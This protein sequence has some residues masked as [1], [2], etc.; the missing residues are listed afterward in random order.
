MMYILDTNVIAD[1][2]HL[3][4]QVRANLA[5]ARQANAD[6]MMTR[7]VYY[8][9]VRGLV[10]Q[11]ATR[12]LRIFRQDL[13]PLMKQ[14]PL[15]DEDWEQAAHFWAAAVSKGRQLSD[16][17]LLLAAMAHRRGATLIS[18][19]TDFDTLPIQRQDWRLA[20]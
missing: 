7:P 15:Q 10:K 9:V 14:E 16:I 6:I 20:T 8:E 4:A 5:A 18:S 17:D 1:L 11:Q 3:N 13:L 12:K 2:I 19:D